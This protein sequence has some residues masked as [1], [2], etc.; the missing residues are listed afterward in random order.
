MASCTPSILSPVKPPDGTMDVTERLRRHL[1]QVDID[2]RPIAAIVLRQGRRDVLVT[3]PR[4]QA[5]KFLADALQAL[6]EL[7]ARLTLV[8]PL[9]GRSDRR[10]SCLGH[11]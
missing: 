8:K 10:R 5:A 7:P 11:A 6:F 9:V 1:Q 2:L 4:R 3:H